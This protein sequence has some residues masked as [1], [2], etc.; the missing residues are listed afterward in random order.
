M[1]LE[2]MHDFARRIPIHSPSKQFVLSGYDGPLNRS[3]ISTSLAPDSTYLEST[4]L[5]GTILLLFGD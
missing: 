2:S 4:F 5:H 3:T 1:S